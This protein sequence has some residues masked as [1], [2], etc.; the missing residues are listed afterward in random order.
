MKNTIKYITV[1][2]LICLMSLSE[3]ISYAQ[4]PVKSGAGIPSAYSNI[5]PFEDFKMNIDREPAVSAEDAKRMVNYV[6]ERNIKPEY[7]D[8]RVKGKGYYK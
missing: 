3:G 7:I 1:G 4:T 5:P 2:I 6:T 8:V